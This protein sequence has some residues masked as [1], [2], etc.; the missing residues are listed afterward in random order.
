MASVLRPLIFHRR[1][2]IWQGSNVWVN[3]LSGIVLPY[4][5][6]VGSEIRLQ[7]GKL[8]YQWRQVTPKQNHNLGNLEEFVSWCC[9][10]RTMSFLEVPLS[11]FPTN[12]SI[13]T[14]TGLA[15]IAAEVPPRIRGRITAQIAGAQKWAI[16]KPA[17]FFFGGKKKEERKHGPITCTYLYLFLFL[18][19]LCGLRF[20]IIYRPWIKCL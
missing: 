15:Y 14:P 13:R 7:N 6:K 18:G 2:W 19:Q 8:V 11:D 12:L 1:R 3:H 16:M 17:A 4:S 10:W 5:S 20:G 9:Q